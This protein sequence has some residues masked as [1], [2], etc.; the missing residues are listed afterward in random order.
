MNIELKNVNQLK[1]NNFGESIECKQN[2]VT[3]K[4]QRLSSFAEY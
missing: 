4:K 1:Y 3:Q 2:K